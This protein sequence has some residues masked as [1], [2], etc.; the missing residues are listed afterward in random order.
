MSLTCGLIF[1][2]LCGLGGW[3]DAI[4]NIGQTLPISDGMGYHLAQLRGLTTME[5][6]TTCILKHWVHSYEEDTADMQVYRPVSYNFPLVRGG[7]EGFEFMAGGK[8]IYYRSAPDDGALEV[9]GRWTLEGP[10][11]VRIDVVDGH[12][13]PLTLGIVSCDDETLKVRQ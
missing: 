13:A 11:R 2:L 5:A 7:R 12:I 9:N 1:G 6:L 4:R 8:L 3:L 10:N